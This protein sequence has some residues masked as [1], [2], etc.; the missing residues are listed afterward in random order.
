MNIKSVELVNTSWDIKN[1]KK[2]K[3]EYI[4]C[5]PSLRKTK[6]LILRPF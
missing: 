5:H 1:E 2:G 3:L 4:S 6:K